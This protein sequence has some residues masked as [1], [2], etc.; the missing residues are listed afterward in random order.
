MQRI[1]L[2]GKKNTITEELYK[3]LSRYY[4]IQFCAEIT[5]ST[6]G[7]MKMILPDLVVINATDM[8]NVDD[9]LFDFLKEHCGGLPVAVV[10]TKEG[11][12]AYLQEERVKGIHPIYRP[13]STA[14][15]VERCA[16]LME[17]RN[18]E[19]INARRE[20]ERKKHIL[21][22]DDSAVT[23]RSVKAL[24]QDKY[25]VSVATSG[26]MA[27]KAMQRNLPDLVL[28][29]YEMPG[30]DGKETLEMIRRDENLKDVPVMFL[31]GVADKQHI[32]AVLQLNPVGYLL[33]P[34]EKGKLL[35]VIEDMFGSEDEA[36]ITFI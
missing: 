26:E 4:Q 19:R 32:A 15:I 11:C 8:E 17:G 5:D 12:S 14:A 35:E 23:L 13:V 31:T 7:M 20:D 36:D 30:C 27:I 2:L 24:L 33:K 10:G 29:D 18:P 1:L 3:C 21:V 9:Q 25:R 34:T 16:G 28:L 6:A 22:V